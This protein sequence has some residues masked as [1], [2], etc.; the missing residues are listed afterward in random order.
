[1]TSDSN[2]PPRGTTPSLHRPAKG[3]PVTNFGEE[4]L[5]PGPWRGFGSVVDPRKKVSPVRIT[6]SPLPQPLLDTGPPPDLPQ[7][8]PPRPRRAWQPPAWLHGSYKPAALTEVGLG[9]LEAL[10][11]AHGQGFQT[12]PTAPLSSLESHREVLAARYVGLDMIQRGH[13]F[14]AYG[15]IHP[16]SMFPHREALETEALCRLN[17]SGIVMDEFE[18]FP[19]LAAGGAMTT[20]QIISVDPGNAANNIRFLMELKAHRIILHSPVPMG[21]GCISVWHL[22]PSGWK[23]LREHYDYLEERGL[24]PLRN[25][26]P[27]RDQ[28][29]G[30]VLAPIDG[31]LR[32]V[33]PLLQT[34]AIIWFTHVAH[35]NGA[36]VEALFLD[37]YL[38]AE[39][40]NTKGL[41]Y[42]DFRMLIAAPDG[43][44]RSLDVEVI[45][46]G[47]PYRGQAA[48][49]R[50]R[51]SPAHNSFSGAG[52][53]IEFGEHV[54]IGR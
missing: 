19:W 17:T 30:R 43:R 36:Y 20:A 21:L 37:K 33:H 50:I 11:P 27:A 41:R 38:R 4:F 26:V 3:N 2:Q 31:G 29:P 34:D 46:V 23:W 45:G 9:A 48:R 24:R 44:R 1:M 53:R 42:L 40:G 18:L 32:M 51:K 13:A 8:T 7:K 6:Y 15:S 28:S 52:N 14:E 10:H 16:I 47:H 22:A 54:T 49:S 25:L 5:F 35:I 39:C 12:Y